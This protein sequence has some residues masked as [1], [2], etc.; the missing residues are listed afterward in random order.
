VLLSCTLHCTARATLCCSA[1]PCPRVILNPYS[2]ALPKEGQTLKVLDISDAMKRGIEIYVGGDPE[3]IPLTDQVRTQIVPLKAVN[4][5]DVQ[6][7]LGEVLKSALAGSSDSS[8]GT[9]AIST[10]SNS[11]ILTGRSEGINRAVRILKVIDVSTRK[12]NIH[13]GWAML[14]GMKQRAVSRMMVPSSIDLLAAA[15]T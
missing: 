9:M 3:T 4:V 8:T 11:V 6:K 1:E 7:E 10:Y 13:N 14:Y 12:P 15:P 5:V 2:P